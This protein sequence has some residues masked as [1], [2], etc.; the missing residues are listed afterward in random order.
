MRINN[1]YGMYD[2]YNSMFQ[3]NMALN[4]TKLYKDLFKTP[5]KD[6]EKKL[7]ESSL[8]YVKNIKSASQGLS[9]SINELSGAAFKGSEE[10]NTD[11][12]KAAVE[13]FVKN[14][15]DL[16]SESVQKSEDPK[17]QKLATKMLNI[18]KIYSGSLASVGIGFDNDG[19]M[20]V[21]SEQLDKAAENG[22]LETFFTQNAGKN[23]G[24]T[25]QLS[26]LANDVNRNTS[27]YVSNSVM[28][29]S[30]MENFG[31]T[32]YGKPTQYNFLTA[33]WLLDMMF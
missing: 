32:G 15:N 11:K 9:K 24:F 22:K 3:N 18:S 13:G 5:N 29:N 12:A 10:G 2:L 19:K 31:Y 7:N 14:Y 27:N 17:A 6:D 33:G 16:Y 8:D 20:K 26:N 25:N 23:Y 4:N 28:G 21:D 1:S 30:L